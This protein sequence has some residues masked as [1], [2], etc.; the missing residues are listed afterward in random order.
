M[1]TYRLQSSPAI[2]AP[3]VVRLAQAA[4]RSGDEAWAVQLLSTWQGIPGVVAEALAAAR[5]PF[6]VDDDEAVVVIVT[7]AFIEEERK[8]RAFK[9]GQLRRAI[10]RAREARIAHRGPKAIAYHLN[11]C[12]TIRASFR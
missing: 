11:C 5:L 10:D 2:C 6:T 7:P 1:T 12:R 4:Y 8:A 3:G 9:K